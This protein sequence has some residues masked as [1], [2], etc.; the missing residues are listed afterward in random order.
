[1]TE[2]I[3]DEATIDII[4]D[5]AALARKLAV[6][7]PFKSANGLEALQAFAAHLDGMVNRTSS[8]QQPVVN[9]AVRTRRKVNVAVRVR[10]KKSA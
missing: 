10:R 9:V 8:S 4:E 3:E 6:K 1:M 7:E 5:I 2:R